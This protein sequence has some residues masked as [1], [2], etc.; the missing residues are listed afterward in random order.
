MPNP[1]DALRVALVRLR[2][3]LFRRSMNDAMQAEM[4]EHLDRATARLVARGMT[5]PA[6]RLEARRE[7]GNVTVLQ[8]EARE[9]RGTR[10]LD[11]IAGDA[12]FALRYFSRHKATTAIIV[13]VIALGTGANTLI[14]SIFQSEFTRP[15][16]A[17]AENPLHARIWAQERPSR[18]GR[19]ESRGFSRTELVALAE[20]REI[21]RDVAA[22]TPDEVVLDGGDSTGARAVNAQFVTPNF[23]AAIGVAL[24]AGQGLR[25]DA[26]ETPDMTAIM[27]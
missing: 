9:A 2:A 4:R 17:V 20:R 19:W 24:A 23:F 16:P 22:W 18:T 1:I 25:Q 26:G 27:A 11:D 12:R 21:F 6:A 10:W 15:A 8:D 7:F 14:F 3:I 13:V 5:E